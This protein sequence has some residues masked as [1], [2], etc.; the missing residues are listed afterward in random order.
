MARFRMSKFQGKSAA[1]SEKMFSKLQSILQE[2]K[3]SDFCKNPINAVI[4]ITSERKRRMRL[5]K[6]RTIST[7]LK[8]SNAIAR[9]KC[10]DIRALK[11]DSVTLKNRKRDKAEIS[12]VPKAV[13]SEPLKQKKT[14]SCDICDRALSTRSNLRRHYLLKHSLKQNE[15][16]NYSKIQFSHHLRNFV[17][18]PTSLCKRSSR[19]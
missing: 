6:K 15:K 19:K 14:F 16:K 12:Q 8:R 13:K 18:M 11:D 5:L 7:N 4:L 1:I 10:K 3:L 17:F 9:K 2:A